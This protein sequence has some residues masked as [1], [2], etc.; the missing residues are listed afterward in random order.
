M[1][2]ERHDGFPAK[3]VL[4][5]ERVER[6]RHIIP[7]IGEADED[8]IVVFQILNTR[9]QFGT[10]PAIN[11]FFGGINQSLVRTGI[12]PD[13]LDLEQVTSRCFADNGGNV[14]RVTQHLAVR[15]HSTGTGGGVYTIRLWN[16]EVGN[17]H[18]PVSTGR[19][20]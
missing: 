12:S 14:L 6:H 16:R 8:N 1:R 2:T 9:G 5:K 15:N 7:P 13:G 20:R 10:G 17:K 18:S 3:I 4:I 19:N 11:F